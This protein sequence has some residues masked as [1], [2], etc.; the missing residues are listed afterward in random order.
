M[1][2]KLV[3]FIEVGLK[4]SQFVW[5]MVTAPFDALFFFGIQ[6]FT[7]YIFRSLREEKDSYHCPRLR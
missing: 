3:I 2:R 1:D 4:V 5:K 7:K 6:G